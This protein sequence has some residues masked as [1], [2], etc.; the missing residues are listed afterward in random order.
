M[1][2][3][4]EHFTELDDQLAVGCY[5]HAPEHVGFLAEQGI[6]A[7]VNLQSDRDLGGLGVVWP[8]MW[9]LYV[10]S[11]IQSTRVPVIDFDRK[12]LLRS[13]EEAVE[14]IRD[15]VNAGRKTYVHCSAGLNRSPTSVIAY[16]V[17]HRGLSVKA[18]LAWLGERH[19]C[20]PYPDVLESWAK[21]RGLPLS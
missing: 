17:A 3:M 2:A 18:A 7:V 15:H 8:I 1:G 4:L 21:R 19:R 5:P 16:L 6:R 11:G 9:Q 13:L 14:A 20:V 10:R 12:D